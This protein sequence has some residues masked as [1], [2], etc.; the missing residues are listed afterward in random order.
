MLRGEIIL[1]TIK[2]VGFAH[3]RIY[4][5]NLSTA[6][7][8]HQR[9]PFHWVGAQPNARMPYCTLEKRSCVFSFSGGSAFAGGW[10]SL[11]SLEPLPARLLHRSFGDEAPQRY[12]QRARATACAYQETGAVQLVRHMIRGRK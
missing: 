9:Y 10:Q 1:R 2:E 3:I 4:A 7:P 8:Q 5:W 6:L 12:F 11:R